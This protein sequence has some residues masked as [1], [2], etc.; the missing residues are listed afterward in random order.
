MLSNENVKTMQEYS[1]NEVAPVMVEFTKWIINESQKKGI[2]KIYFLARDGFL[3][4]KIAKE[5]CKK[6]KL[7][8]DCKYLYCSRRA[9]R[10]PCYHFIGDEAYDQLFAK[11]Y[12]LTLNSVFNK[13]GILEKE[14]KSICEEIN[15]EFSNKLLSE[16]Q[17]DEITNKLK[18]NVKFNELLMKNSAKAYKTAM[19]YFNQEELFNDDKI[20]IVDSGWTGTIQRSIRQIA[21]SVDY[22]G[23]IHGFYFGMVNS[24]KEEDGEYNTFYFNKSSGLRRKVLFNS[25]LFECMLSANHGMTLGYKKEKNAVKPVLTEVKNDDMLQLINM[26]IDGV[27][28]FVK[29]NQDLLKLDGYDKKNSQKTC[30]KHLKRVMVYPTQQE[31]KML[32]KFM[33]CDD[34]S[35]DYH[36]SLAD[37]SM[38]KALKS[39]MI[40]PRVFGMI[41][42]KKKER[43]NLYWPYGVIAFEPKIIRPGQRFNIKAWD[44]IRLLL[45]K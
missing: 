4:Q 3:I 22:K 33:F 29:K 8:V 30:F 11:G 10:M 24:P 6:N 15:C 42:G 20:A 40:L 44:T 31:A 36:V 45:K 27:M 1:Y 32:G 14:A 23:K 19:Q 43:V 21:D 5:I 16:K 38:K 18:N 13:A 37:E 7:N 2:N 9:L 28:S 34:M 17:Y 12:R 35:E 39:S 25:N 26:Q 41:F